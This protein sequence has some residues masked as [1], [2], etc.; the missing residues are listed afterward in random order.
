MNEHTQ[1]AHVYIWGRL[2]NNILTIS[3]DVGR[4]GIVYFQVE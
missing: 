1:Q 4:T 3:S 2:A